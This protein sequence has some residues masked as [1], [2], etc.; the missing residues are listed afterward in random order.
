MN[1]TL[2]TYRCS[3]LKTISAI[4]S[5]LKGLKVLSLVGSMQNMSDEVFENLIIQMKTLV[6]LK[7]P[8]CKKITNYTFQS[9]V[10]KHVLYGPKPTGGL[11]NLVLL[12]ISDNKHVDDMTLSWI[13]AGCDGLQSFT[14]RHC[15]TNFDLGCRNFGYMKF[16]TY[17]DLSFCNGITDTGLRYLSLGGCGR[18]LK[19]LKFQNMN[20]VS[21]GPIFMFLLSCTSVTDLDLSGTI[22]LSDKNAAICL[23]KNCNRCKN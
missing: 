11:P 6:S 1:Y 12:E 20:S 4:L 8:G 10:E 16:L 15:H 22:N 7:I 2:T 5:S 17:L 19:T 3:L 13:A 23:R 18:K 14:L 21:D 9:L